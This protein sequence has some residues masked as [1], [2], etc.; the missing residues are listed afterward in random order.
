[1]VASFEEGQRQEKVEV[2]LAVRVV[3]VFSVK[4]KSFGVEREN[5]GESQRRW[6]ED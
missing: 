5:F 3:R 1:M 6:Q 4:A 2:A